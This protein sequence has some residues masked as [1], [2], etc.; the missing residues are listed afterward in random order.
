MTSNDMPRPA[1][2]YFWVIAI[3]LTFWG[4]VGCY[5][6]YLQLVEGPAAMGPATKY[7]RL[8]YASL[9][10][11]YNYVYGVAAATGLFGGLALLLRLGW[12]GLLFFI[13]LI[14]IVVQFGYLFIATDIIVKKGAVV[15]LP[16]PIFILVMCLF[17]IWFAV[18][19]YRHDWVS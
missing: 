1:P 6:C 17:S 9:P 12:A 15:V 13:S 16:F 7:G 14:A 2:F 10:E 11:W 5:A 8:L 18:Q 4:A 3:L 19:A